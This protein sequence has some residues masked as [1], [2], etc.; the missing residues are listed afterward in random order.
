MTPNPRSSSSQPAEI[1]R[2][3]YNSR[4][5]GQGQLVLTS[6]HLRKDQKE[7]VE[8]LA[9]WSGERQATVIRQILDEWCE[10]TLSKQ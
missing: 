1:I 9:A 3:A 6:F 4:Q 5:D 7:L 8:A 10:M 2:A